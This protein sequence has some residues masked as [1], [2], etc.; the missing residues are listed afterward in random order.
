MPCQ[1][2]T[3]VVPV[4]VLGLA[5]SAAGLAAQRGTVSGGVVFEHELS[6][7][8]SEGGGL[9]WAVAAGAFLEPTFLVEG[10]IRSWRYDCATFRRCALAAVFGRVRREFPIRRSGVA[11]GAGVRLGAVGFENESGDPYWGVELAPEIS[12]SRHIDRLRLELS[13]APTLFG[14]SG[15]GGIRSSLAVGFSARVVFGSPGS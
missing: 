2:A 9:G 8:D 11:A 6:G 13:L 5:V 12:L 1:L 14:L 3:R 7:T 10:G 15:V 4:L